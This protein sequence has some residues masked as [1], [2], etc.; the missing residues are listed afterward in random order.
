MGK[1]FKGELPGAVDLITVNNKVDIMMK[2]NLA[3]AVSMAVA[4]MALSA[5]ASNSWASTT[6]YNTYKAFATATPTDGGAS[7]NGSQANGTDGWV[8]G[9]KWS[10]NATPWAGPGTPA[11]DQPLP[12][13]FVGI[14]GS[15]TPSSA[16]P[17]GYIGSA[18]VNW[19]M[20]LT[21]AA[22][23][24]VISQ[25]DSFSRYGVYADID[26]GKGAWSDNISLSTAATASGWRHN[27]DFGLF[28]SA[29]ETD[30]HLHVAGLTQ[31]GTNFGFT[32][33]KGMDTNQTDAYNHHGPWN[34]GNNVAGVTV[35]TLVGGDTTFTVDDVV[36]Y[37]VGG[38]A[39]SNL[40]DI[41]FHAKADQVYTILLG[42][43]R[44]G[45]WVNTADGYVLTASAVPIP[46][47]V[48][49]FGSAVAGMIGFGRRKVL[50]A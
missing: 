9:F 33:F 19:A 35:D 25:A 13:S 34:S 2:T 42:G 27:V 26:T 21:G 29:V 16:T 18:P 12:P 20:E 24:G 44:N 30:I 14:N 15:A 38:A 8:W 45:T 10:S 43:Y 37:S 5:G 40:N 3:K 39:P 4:G 22:D 11:G 7:A 48:W 41:T 49:L 32:I 6:M 1:V 28:R 47:A 23:S 50:T 46:S 36:A 31:A 17:F